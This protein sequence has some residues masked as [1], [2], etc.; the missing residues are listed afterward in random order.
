MPASIF[1]RRFVGFEEGGWHRVGTVITTPMNAE[2]ALALMG[3]YQ[4][5]LEPVSVQLSEPDRSIETKHL[6]IVRHPTADD[7]QARLFGMVKEGYRLVT[8]L[9]FCRT[10][11]K[12]TQG[13]G[14]ETIGVLH[15][16]AALF[17]C[18]ALPDIG[19]Y[20]D[21]H[22]IYLT[23][24]ND[25]SGRVSLRLFL[26]AVRSVCANTV[27]AGWITASEQHRIRHGAYV[28][29]VMEHWLAN[30]IERVEAKADV[31]KETFE[32]M[33]RTR[34]GV[35]DL[36]QVLESTYPQRAYPDLSIYSP[37]R[38]DAIRARIDQ[39][40]ERVGGYREL[41]RQL[42][43]GAATGADHPNMQGTAYG[44]YQSI[45][46]VEDWRKGP[47]KESALVGSRAATKAKAFRAIEGVVGYPFS[48]N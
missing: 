32:V 10:A 28:L 22:K 40:N 30:M 37:E 39:D 31:L 15:H 25:M 11:D 4:I 43:Q 45:V 23:L 48:R 3:D 36:R 12:A 16:G 26:S 46:E 8:P 6:G 38:A 2:A 20:G 17:L 19:I 1:G 41:A 34:L 44:L 24:S 33:A 42:F 5:T 9:E 29:E 47:A 21:E 18:Y 35:G 7:P 27:E 13:R 14:I